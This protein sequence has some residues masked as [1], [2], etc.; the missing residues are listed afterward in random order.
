MLEH[1]IQS[2][3]FQYK[4]PGVSSLQVNQPLHSLF[5]KLE[6]STRVYRVDEVQE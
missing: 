5:E 4:I 3:I 1:G 2:G 6:N